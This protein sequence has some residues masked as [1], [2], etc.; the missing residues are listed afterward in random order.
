MA[1][2]V[3]L[4]DKQLYKM[5]QEMKPVLRIQMIYIEKMRELESCTLYIARVVA[6]HQRL[7]HYYCF[8]AELG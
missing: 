1:I 3:I 7:H 4:M 6:D 2:D 5:N 8:D